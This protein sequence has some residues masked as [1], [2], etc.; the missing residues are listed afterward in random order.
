MAAPVVV[1]VELHQCCREMMES[2][3]EPDEYTLVAVFAA[4]SRAKF[5]AGTGFDDVK[6][7][8]K[9]GDMYNVKLNP[10]VCG[11]LVQALRRCED[12]EPAERCRLAEKVLAQAE[13]ANVKMNS[14]I[15]NS[16]ISLYWESHEYTAAR[17]QYDKMIDLGVQP[18]RRT[19]EIMESMCFEAGWTE[20]AVAFREL[21]ESMS[22]YE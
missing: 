7:V 10:F 3:V 22:L 5:R 2:G 21:K 16:M 11:A 6:N 8:L 15:M 9:V 17:E 14:T 20:E 19:C 18:E 1:V 13:S 12:I 4:I